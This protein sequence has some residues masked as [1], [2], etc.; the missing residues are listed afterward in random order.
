MW[1]PELFLKFK[2]YHD[3]HPNGTISVDELSA[4]NQI[5]NFTCEPSFDPVV[6]QGTIATS[7]FS[8]LY[9]F[10]C[11]FLSM[12]IQTKTI[13]VVSMALGGISA[14]C[15]Y[16]LK[17]SLQ[18]LVVACV[19]QASMV[20]ANMT[21]GS[22]GVDLFPTKVSAIA[23]CLIMCAGRVGAVCSNVIFGYLMDRRCEIP[24]FAVAAVVLLGAA[25]C[26]VLPNK[27]HP[28][29]SASNARDDRKAIEVAVIS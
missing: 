9:N 28:A 7:A 10:T 14:G 20:T 26:T 8:L 23:L 16:W 19:F 27:I 13:S 18:N 4:L 15:I 6:I 11:G 24:I 12:R 1:I 17:S 21:I 29:S 5:S 22:I 2:R 3:L 25:L